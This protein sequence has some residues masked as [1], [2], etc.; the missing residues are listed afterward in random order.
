MIRMVLRQA[1]QR[2]K[3]VRVRELAGEAR[4]LLLL[5]LL[6]LTLGRRTP[7]PIPILIRLRLWSERVHR[8][9]QLDEVLE[10]TGAHVC[11]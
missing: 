2:P 11:A 9:H 4:V 3:L 7:I 6:P 1:L 8:G 5:C 10:S